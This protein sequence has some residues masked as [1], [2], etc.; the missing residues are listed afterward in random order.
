MGSEADVAAARAVVVGAC[1][2]RCAGT[3][4]VHGC[5]RGLGDRV[6]DFVFSTVGWM[7]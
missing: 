7:Y 3:V 4:L 2:L 6:S 1:E 5:H